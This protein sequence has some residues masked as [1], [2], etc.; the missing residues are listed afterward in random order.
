MYS[1]YN[2]TDE[3][4]KLLLSLFPPKHNRKFV[5]HITHKFPDSEKPAPPSKVMVVGHCHDNVG[6]CLV[7][8]VDGETKRPGGGIYH[9]T[10]STKGRTGPV[11]SNTL[12]KNAEVKYLDEPIEISV[13]PS[14]NR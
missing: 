2:L 12:L 1:A 5:H 4:K 10:V 14:L 6:E 9:I 7:V 3:S 11:Y 13:V 8:A